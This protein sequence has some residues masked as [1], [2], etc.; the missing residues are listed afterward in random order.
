MVEYNHYMPC[1]LLPNGCNCK[2]YGGWTDADWGR[3]GSSLWNRTDTRRMDL[4][5]SICINDI[6]FI[7]C[8]RNWKRIKNYFKHLYVFLYLLTNLRFHLWKYTIYR[9]NYIRGNRIYH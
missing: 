2:L 5:R 3:I 7:L 4:D 6:Y 8:F 9:R 1:D